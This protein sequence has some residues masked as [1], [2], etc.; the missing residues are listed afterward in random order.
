MSSEDYLRESSIIFH[1]GQ[2]RTVTPCRY[3]EMATRFRDISRETPI[4]LCQDECN[5]IPRER[6][7][8]SLLLSRDGTLMTR[9]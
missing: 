6:D 4:F 3:G 9:R 8:R 2:T 7:K 1:M 5:A